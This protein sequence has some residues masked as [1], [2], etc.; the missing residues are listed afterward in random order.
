MSG[1][2]M[3]LKQLRRPKSRDLAFHILVLKA[4]REQ[5]DSNP[6]TELLNKYS[7]YIIEDVPS[8]LSISNEGDT[9]WYPNK[10]F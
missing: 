1:E 7:F 10:I 3:Q 2:A 5:C 6:L 9:K 4:M 8:D